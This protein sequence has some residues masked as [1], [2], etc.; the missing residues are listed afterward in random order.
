MTRSNA[1]EYRAS[2]RPRVQGTATFTASRQLATKALAWSEEGRIAFVTSNYVQILTPT[3]NLHPSIVPTHH[4]TVYPE[5]VS[6][7]AQQS[8]RTSYISACI[9]PSGEHSSFSNVKDMGINAD[10][11]LQ[12]P[13]HER[14]PVR[15]VE[16]SPLGFASAR[17][18]YLSVLT[19]GLELLLYE[20]TPNGWT[21]TWKESRKLHVAPHD[22]RSNREALLDTH[23]VAHR[24]TSSASTTTGNVCFLLASTRSGR[25]AAWKFEAGTDTVAVPVELN[26]PDRFHGHI[27][28][29][30]ACSSWSQADTSG[31]GSSSS[32]SG[33][34]TLTCSVAL[35]SPA[36]S[37]V[38]IGE[39]RL[40]SSSG[41][42]QLQTW[43]KFVEGCHCVTYARFIDSRNQLV[44]AEPGAVAVVELTSESKL[45][46]QT[47]ILEK[48]AAD[49]PDIRAHL[50]PCS[51]MIN[52]TSHGTQTLHVTLSDGGIYHLD[53]A[54]VEGAAVSLTVSVKPA[55]EVLTIH[56][57]GQ[58]E[59]DIQEQI[60]IRRHLNGYVEYPSFATGDFA[61]LIAVS[62]DT[63]E[64]ATLS[65]RINDARSGTV[66]LMLT[67]PF[68]NNV[69][70]PDQIEATGIIA[71]R[72][73]NDM[74]TLGE[75][76]P[77]A[78]AAY[79]FAPVVSL[80][81]SSAKPS[82]LRI[83]EG[84]W[85]ATQPFTDNQWMLKGSIR[86]LRALNW[87]MNWMQRAGPG[88]VADD[89]KAA[90]RQV[91]GLLD[92][93]NLHGRLIAA[94]QELAG[95][96]EEIQS[97]LGFYTR[98]SAAAMLLSKEEYGS[99][100]AEANADL[101]R[102]LE[103]HVPG[104][105]DSLPKWDSDIS[106][107]GGVNLGEQCP[108][109]A[110][111]LMLAGAS[112]SLRQ[113]RCANRHIWKRCSVSLELLSE[114]SVQLCTG[115]GEGAL[116]LDRH[117]SSGKPHA[118]HN[119]IGE[120]FADSKQPRIASDQH[121]RPVKQPTMNDL[122]RAQS[123]SLWLNISAFV[124]S[125][126]LLRQSPTDTSTNNGR[127]GWVIFASHAREAM[128]REAVD[129]REA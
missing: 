21:G 30:V 98:L 39:L 44:L 102:L 27:V 22:T 74:G 4:M 5:D 112:C 81:L 118:E 85:R 18:S 82:Q 114:Q 108:A 106:S 12:L 89:F 66:V 93:R 95:E 10:S 45:P 86:Q 24:W 26:S 63:A 50:N 104:L 129:A 101:L 110:T 94:C 87:I 127:G 80:F 53:T 57:E 92:V 68:N 35:W 60:S 46:K 8:R 72:I 6:N 33:S 117:G 71:R 7:H 105:R 38:A 19:S 120:S 75:S 25:I 48:S 113:A 122:G 28:H 23:I 121:A 51:T 54:R 47:F 34:S 58:A 70:G 103:K 78:F 77:D 36:H 67:H 16:W 96:N 125:V 128:K 83:M 84:I 64:L 61:R 65:F 116:A 73:L 88:P 32:N 13:S 111:P 14:P 49:P 40:A 76:L 42:P 31:S 17:G 119:S 37:Q 115:C 56:L 126:L 59:E 62:Q 124:A 11:S 2:K 99:E 52:A 90:H 3:F 15:A 1:A 29:I 109:C 9:Q 20:A 43:S 69:P 55:G 79:V 100:V 97:E 107:S 41:Q 123:S 91:R